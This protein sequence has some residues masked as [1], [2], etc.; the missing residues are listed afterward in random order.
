MLLIKCS[1][2]HAC[3][4]LFA[5]RAIPVLLSLTEYCERIIV[6]LACFPLKGHNKLKS[7]IV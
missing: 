5:Q 7:D 1:P 6:L 3:Q 2:R 4:D